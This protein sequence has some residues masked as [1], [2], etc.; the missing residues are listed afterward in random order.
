VH[1]LH[2]IHGRRLK[3]GTAF[4]YDHLIDFNHYGL[5]LVWQIDKKCGNSEALN[6]KGE[7]LGM[8]CSGSK[9]TLLSLGDPEEP[10]KSLILDNSNES[11][12]FLKKIRKYN[13][14]FQMTSFGVDKDIVLHGL[15]TTFTIQ[16]QMYH[17][18]G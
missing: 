12:H 10:L 1:I 8:C 3:I 14:C 4:D 2:V 11:R 16:G 17:K 5:V 6:W 13:C 15:S 18:V 9:V 7:T